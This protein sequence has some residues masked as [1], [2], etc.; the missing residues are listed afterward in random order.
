M[1]RGALAIGVL[2]IAVRMAVF[3][4]VPDALVQDPDAYRSLAR[5]WASTGTFGTVA[6]DASTLEDRSAAHS[7]PDATAA[8]DGVVATA[9]RP[10]L[11]PWLLSWAYYGADDLNASVASPAEPNHRDRAWIAFWHIALGT[12]TSVLTWLLAMRLGLRLWAGAFAA[13]LVIGDPILLR[14]STLVMTE[15]LATFLGVVA[16][17][18]AVRDDASCQTSDS[19]S[20]SDLPGTRVRSGLRAMVPGLFLGSLLGAAGLCRATAL[21]W[22]VIWGGLCAIQWWRSSERNRNPQSIRTFA[23]AA[24]VACL[25]LGGWAWRN[26]Q[27][28]GAPILTTTHGGYTLYLANNPVLYDHWKR[29]VSR[30]WDE[31]AFHRDWRADLQSR[32]FASEMEMDRFAQSLA[33]QSIREEPGTFLWGCVIRQGWFWALW[34][35]SRQASDWQQRAIGIWYAIALGCA[36]WGG[37][38]LARSGWRKG[39]TT[40]QGDVDALRL[41]L[42]AV[43]LLVS[44]ILVHSVYWSNMRMRA[45][46]VPMLSLL[47][48]VGVQGLLGH[49]ATARDGGQKRTE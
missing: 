3:A 25:M 30:D 13:M 41:W 46:L 45:P 11:Y 37:V 23:V 10:P 7:V 14:Q 29:S 40:G 16:W 1:L 32:V 39:A 28:L 31:D 18:W 35:S 2:A 24:V 49:L 38:S 6:A 22:L 36:A 43:A 26:H 47:A 15:T 12:A 21:A 33:M 4:V 48:A 27:Q 9:Y 44:L 17:W 19:D 34:P 20:K 5:V 8:K 42:P